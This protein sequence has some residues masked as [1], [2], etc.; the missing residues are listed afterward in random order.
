MRQNVLHCEYKTGRRVT[1]TGVSV[2]GEVNGLQL[3]D[4]FVESFDQAK[5]LQ[6]MEWLSNGRQ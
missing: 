1:S 2:D 5:A 3:H 6:L 4:T